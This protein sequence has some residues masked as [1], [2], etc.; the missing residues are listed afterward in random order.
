MTLQQSERKNV[1]IKMALKGC[2]S[3]GKSLSSLL[4]AKGLTNGD[5]SKVVVIDTENSIDLYS[6]IGKFNVLSLHQPYS[7]ESYIQAINECE[8]A[9]MEVIIID[10]ISHCW[11]YLLQLHGTMEGNSFTNWNKISPLQNAFVDKITQSPCHIICTMR[12]KQDYI[13]QT[14]NGKTT[15]EKI[16]LKAIQRNEIEYEFTIVLDID[17]THKAKAIKD[18]TNLFMDKPAFKI[19]EATGIDI[20]SWC[21]CDVKLDSVKEKIKQSTTIEELKSIFTMYPHFYNLL[22]EDFIKQKE[23]I[24]NNNLKLNNHELNSNHANCAKHAN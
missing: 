7:P 23:L 6:H 18:R 10:S 12:S 15:I 22:N 11:H 9:G 3:S 24:S 16:G 5:L 2:S 19:T 20:L 4:I 17:M 8:K 13:I 21:S 1:K 14:N